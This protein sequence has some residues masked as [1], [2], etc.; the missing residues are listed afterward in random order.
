MICFIV[1]LSIIHNAINIEWSSGRSA[2]W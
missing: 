2:I 1:I